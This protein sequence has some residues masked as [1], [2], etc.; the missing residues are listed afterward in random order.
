MCNFAPIAFV[1]EASLDNRLHTR[2][3]RRLGFTRLSFLLLIG[4]SVIK[5]VM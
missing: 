2:S 4:L 1:S 3:L 5:S